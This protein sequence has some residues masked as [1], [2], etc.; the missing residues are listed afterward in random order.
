MGKFDIGARVRHD[1]DVCEVIGKPEKGKRELRVLG[2]KHDGMVFWAPKSELEVVGVR[3]EIGKTY[4]DRDGVQHG[5][6]VKN[7]SDPWVGTHP[8]A[9][10]D[11][12]WRVDGGFLPRGEDPWDLVAEVVRPAEP[13]KP[14]FEVGQRVTVTT[15][16][17]VETADAPYHA[18]IFAVGDDI[19]LVF[20][21]WNG[22]HDGDACDGSSNHYHYAASDITPFTLEAGKFYRTRDGRKVGPM[23][24]FPRSYE[25]KHPWTANAPEHGLLYTDDGINYDGIR[26]PRT[27]VAEWVEP[28]IVVEDAMDPWDPAVGDKI[29]WLGKFNATMLTVGS[30]YEIK[31]LNN[32]WVGITDDNQTHGDHSWDIA[33]LVDKLERVVEPQPKFKV[34]DR[35]GDFNPDGQATIRI[36]DGDKFRVQWDGEGE[37]GNYWWKLSQW[38]YH[39]PVEPLAVGAEVVLTLPATIRMIH[40]DRASLLM[41]SGGAFTLPIASLRLAA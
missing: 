17:W 34:G 41:P 29:K 10:G 33:D 30:V 20:D 15:R 18:T 26:D 24:P 37:V 16:G 8:F 9:L 4:V 28:T 36:V 38:E 1:G 11:R 2:G 39:T 13:A 22:G 5:P 40:G 25:N 19:D 23:V 7:T 14:Q 3:L 21:G 32:G 31:R 12:S 35:V 27:I 6:L